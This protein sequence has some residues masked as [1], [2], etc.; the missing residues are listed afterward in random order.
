MKVILKDNIEDLGKKGDIVT[1]APG[2]GRNYL[3]PKKLALEVTATNLKMIEMVQK[4][5]RKGL[6]KEMKVVQSL[7]ERLSTVTLTFAR[8]AGEKDT[9]FGSVSVNDIRE[10]LMEQNFDIEKKRILLDEPLKRLGNYTVPIKV[11]HE[12]R[13]E[14]SVEVVKEGAPAEEEAPEVEAEPESVQAA[15]PAAEPEPEPETQPEP[16]PEPEPEPETGPQPTPEPEIEAEAETE[17]V[18]ESEPD[19]EPAQSAEAE[20]EAAEEPTAET[21]ADA[22]AETPTEPP[23]EATPPEEADA[24]VEDAPPAEDSDDKSKD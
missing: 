14:I 8:K 17:A 16:V 22:P 18:P 23:V 9:I 15:P 10:A 19:P 3:I 6:E 4:S 7:I 5:L 21:P 12:D 20:T 1:V 2:Y 24:S 13:A 11:F